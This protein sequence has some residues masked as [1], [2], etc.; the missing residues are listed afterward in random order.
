MKNFLIPTTLKEDTIGAVKKAIN[1]AKGNDCKIT[2]MLISEIPDSYSS[3]SSFLRE[4]TNSTTV[5]EE[6]ILDICREIV[7]KVDN[8]SLKIHNQYGISSPIFKRIIEHFSLNLIIVTHSYHQEEK[9]IIQNL[10]Q[11]LDNQKCPILHLGAL[12]NQYDFKKALYIENTASTIPI[13]D[14]QQFINNNF[15]SE[16]VS[17]TSD[18]EATNL[19]E[20]TPYLTEVISKNGINLLVKTRKPKKIKLKKSPKQDN[21]AFLGLSVLSLY[22]EMVLEHHFQELSLT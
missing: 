1:L 16:I 14:L 4:M 3:P 11:L 10:I 22:E 13:A 6:N 17:M 18:N 8:C 19:E 21:N 2:L 9:R 20:F 15:S 5:N 7:S 12:E